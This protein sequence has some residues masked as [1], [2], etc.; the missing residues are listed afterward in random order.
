[1]V[2]SGTGCKRPGSPAQGNQP[3][4]AKSGARRAS[5]TRGKLTVHVPI[6]DQGE[7]DTLANTLHISERQQP[8]DAEAETHDW[9]PT[10]PQSPD[11]MSTDGIAAPDGDLPTTEALV[12]DL[13]GYA[14]Y[15]SQD[16]YVSEAMSV[17][18]H[19]KR[20]ERH[21]ILRRFED[22]KTCKWAVEMREAHKQHQSVG[23]ETTEGEMTEWEI[24]ELNKIPRDHPNYRDLLDAV[25]VGLPSREHPREAWR[26]FTKLYL[27][28]HE[29]HTVARHGHN[30]DR[31]LQATKDLAKSKQVTALVHKGHTVPKTAQQE[32]NTLRTL[33]NKLLG[34]LQDCEKLSAKLKTNRQNT[35]ALKR[36]ITLVNAFLDSAVDS[37][38]VWETLTEDCDAQE[39]QAVLADAKEL[40][41][42]CQNNITIFTALLHEESK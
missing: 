27:Y 10:S 41:R 9:T 15:Q 18:K 39:Q 6:P 5:S 8:A 13:H 7:P 21:E 1:M 33:E 31:V 12:P 40:K 3:A 22:D 42:R 17:Y 28:H 16:I 2:A 26:P 14:L 23:S 25:L 35:D 19:R 32:I 37:V 20:E 30:E 29:G 4:A 11:C 24:G 38:A 34:T 36:G